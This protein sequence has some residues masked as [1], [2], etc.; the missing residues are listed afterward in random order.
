MM[1]K[2][3]RNALAVASMA[4][5]AVAAPM[6]AE[7]QSRLNFEGSASF[8]SGPA[9]SDM[10]IDFLSAGQISGP[11]T[12]TVIA[13]E[14]ISGEFTPEITVGTTGV[15]RDL[16]FAGNSVVGAPV[17]DF[18]SIGGYTFSLGGVDAG[19]NFGPISLFEIGGSTTAAFSVF[20][21]V[22]GPDF[23]AP[24]NYQGIFTTQFSGQ[25]MATVQNSIMSPNGTMP[26]AISAEF[27]VAD[28]QVVPEP[29][30]VA[31]LGTGIVGLGLF[32][33]RRRATQA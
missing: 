20:G 8:S 10:L 31:L 15:I 6:S 3:T 27:I 26:V 9:G 28:A 21:T 13:V 5:A 7:A 33:V 22:T 25:S 32:G 18:V 16:Q 30:T 29:A 24:R 14:T 19:G 4:L 11:P 2:Y 1:R 17:A 12:G 23:A